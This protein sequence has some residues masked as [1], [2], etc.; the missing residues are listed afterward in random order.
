MNIRVLDGLPYIAA[1]LA[2]QGRQITLD[3]VLLDTG[4]MGSIFVTTQPSLRGAFCRRSSLLHDCN[5]R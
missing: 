1:T 5:V 2:Y 3:R 4:S